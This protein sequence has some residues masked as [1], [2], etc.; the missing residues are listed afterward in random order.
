MSF[1]TDHCVAKGLYEPFEVE[2]NPRSRAEDLL[3]ASLDSRQAAEWNKTR[4]I[5][6][7]TSA[8]QRYKLSNSNE[9]N[10]LVLDVG[11]RPP[12]MRAGVVI[13]PG[14][15]L[16]VYARHCPPS[17]TVL[18]ELLMLKGDREDELIGKALVW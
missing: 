7:G 6:V 16:C 17:D 14:L 1:A 13:Y 11:P 9:G 8:G 10:I 3:R 5:V 2:V 15:A 12:S 18:A 4:S